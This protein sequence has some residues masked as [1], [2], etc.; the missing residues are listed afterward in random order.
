MYLRLTVDI[1][2]FVILVIEPIKFVTLS[3]V[4]VLP[5]AAHL[6]VFGK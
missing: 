6:E 1:E 2:C 3:F 4:H 5:F